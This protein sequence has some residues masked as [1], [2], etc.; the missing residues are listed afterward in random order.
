V[1]PANVGKTMKVTNM[2]PRERVLPNGNKLISHKE[3]LAKVPGSVNFSV[4]TYSINP[5]LPVPFKWLYPIANRY[6]SYR[7]RKLKYHFVNSKSGTFAGDVILGID[8]DASDAAP[9]NED[10]LQSYWGAKTGQIC[11]PLVLAA[12]VSALHKLGPNRFTRIGALSAN[13]DIKL[14]DCGNFFIATT[15]CADTSTIGRVFVEYEIELI[16]PQL[17]DTPLSADVVAVGESAAAP[18]GTSLTITGPNS[19]TWISGTT[20]SFDVPGQYLLNF[21]VTGTT[22]TGAFGI[23]SN[24]GA[25]TYK[26]S[27]QGGSSINSAAT[28]AIL[29]QQ[30]NVS[31]TTDV[32]TVSVTAAT[33]TDTRIGISPH[34]Y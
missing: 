2:K 6:E 26:T 4:V 12:D 23:A 30:V 33:A 15:D 25:S 22:I 24:T 9:F 14:Y 3:F 5:G 21:H 34:V 29:A 16:T 27:G 13:Q 11:E 19:I 1:K 28:Y 7:F 31:S 18:L 32:F 20:F 8:Y 17:Q 10:N